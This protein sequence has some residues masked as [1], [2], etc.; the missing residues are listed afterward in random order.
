MEFT[1]HPVGAVFD[2]TKTSFQVMQDIQE[3]AG[4]GTYAPFR[5]AEE[6]ELAEWLIKN[7]NQQ[8]MEDF[9]KLP[10]THN[11]TQP[12]YHSKYLFM[13]AIDQLPTGPEW[14]CELIR[15]HGNAVLD[16]PMGN[17]EADGEDD[18]EELELWL[19]D[20]VACVREL[21][22]NPTFKDDI[23]YTPEKVYADPQGQTRW[24]DEM[25]TGDW[26]WETQRRMPASATITPGDKSAWPVYLSIGNISKQ[27]R[28]QPAS[29]ASVLLGYLPVSKLHSFDDNS[30]ASYRLF[31]YCMKKIL[32]P[33]VVAGQEGV[34]MV[35]ADGRVWRVFSILAA[36][37][38]DHPEQCLIAC[39]TENR[40][41][42]CLVRVDQRGEH[43]ECPHRNQA[44]TT[45]ILHAQATSQYPPEFIAQGLRTIFSPFWSDLP[46]TDIF[47]CISSDIL[48][49]LLQGLLKDY[50]KK[51]CTNIAGKPNFDAHFRAMPYFPGLRHW[52]RGI[53]KVK[54]WTG[55]DHKQ[56][57]RVF[58]TALIGAIPHQDVIKAS[59]ALIDFIH[60]AQFQSQ[61]DDTILALQRALV[62]FHRY[63]DIFI[64]LGCREHFNIPKL[65][66]LTHY[67]ST[68]KNFGSLD[69]VN[70]EHSERLHIDYAKKVYA[71]SNHKDYTI[72]MTKWLQRQE[73]VIWFRSF[74]NWRHHNACDDDDPDATPLDAFLTGPRYRV[75]K[76]P[77]FAKKTI[78]YLIEQH[79]AV[80]FTEAL[81]A[82]VNMLPHAHQFFEPNIYD[83][84]D[85]FSNIVITLRPHEHV[86][87]D[88]FA[89]IRCHIRKPTFFLG[90]LMHP[91]HLNGPRK[92]P[93]PAQFDTVLVLVDEEEHGRA[94][95]FH[96]LHVAEIRAIFTLPPHLGN[97]HEPVAYVHWFKP[98]S[99]IDNTIRM[100]R[101]SRST[102]N[103]RPNAGIV[104]VSQLIQPCHLVPKFP[105]GAVD[106]LWIRH[107]TVPPADTFYLNRYINLCTFEQYRQHEA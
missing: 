45:N 68:I 57:Q 104:P 78:K 105:S 80:G 18:A 49:Q 92:P 22:S 86:S 30:L 12:S 28:R 94:G 87:N 83:R 61:M 77:H 48:H 66:S 2:D 21:I 19:R 76:R 7:V 63:K 20:P 5:D 55:S 79:G 13:K 70:T 32:Q 40:C 29:H 107:H 101:I 89:R 75:A 98:F 25:W 71:K 24:Y 102:R 62:D 82:F 23:A 41:P 103:H 50:V 1:E 97:F 16:E 54:Q 95:G 72:Q 35:C 17:V 15:V 46:H 43:I 93:T 96:G 9:L 74:L 99:H 65:H 59:C 90:L 81:K 44:Q 88:S 34:K 60:I 58:V 100:F 85:C 33:L 64:E 73:A 56:L 6:W 51:W 38:A 14:S 36:Y 47:T 42:K 11:R 26:W 67:V 37:V 10:I 27:T 84:F 91:Q 4:W 3:A 8:G 69:G 106:P 53:S 52:K 39:C 31:H